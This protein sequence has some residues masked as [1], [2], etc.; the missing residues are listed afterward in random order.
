MNSIFDQSITQ[1]PV[2][3][4]QQI[5]DLDLSGAVKRLLEMTNINTIN[6]DSNPGIM[7][8]RKSVV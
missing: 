4:S 5:G 8:D 7:A 1:T 2:A 6:Y 3:H